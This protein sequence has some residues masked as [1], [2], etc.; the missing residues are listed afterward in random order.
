[1]DFEA[2]PTA[3][4]VHGASGR[5]EILRAAYL[6]G[7]DDADAFMAEVDALDQVGADLSVEVTGPWPPYSFVNSVEGKDQ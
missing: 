6:V 3:P 7:R 5:I 2:S 4:G 1:M